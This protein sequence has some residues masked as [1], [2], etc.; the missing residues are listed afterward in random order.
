MMIQ[1]GRLFEFVREVIHIRNEEME[2]ETAWEFW[3][4]KVFEQS[5]ADFRASLNDNST[6][7]APTH[8]ELKKTVSDSAMMLMNFCPYGGGDEQGGTVQADGND[9]G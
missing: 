8:E 3:L 6:N 2:E 9:S 4:H 1:S 5:W 7:A